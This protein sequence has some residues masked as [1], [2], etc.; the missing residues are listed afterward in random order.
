MVKEKTVSIRI[1]TSEYHQMKEYAI[2]KGRKLSR[3]F[4]QAVKEFL[5]KRKVYKE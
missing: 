5:K 3:L 2:I 4:S 1:A